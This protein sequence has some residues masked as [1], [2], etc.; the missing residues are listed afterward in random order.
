MI[1]LRCEALMIRA[2]HDERE[3]VNENILLVTHIELFVCP[4]CDASM[5]FPITLAPEHPAIGR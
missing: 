1:C 4:L 5:R 2:E 3:R